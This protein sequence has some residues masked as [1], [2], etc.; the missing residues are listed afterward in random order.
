MI[1]SGRR[2]LVRRGGEDN[3]GS[4]LH[5]LLGTGCEAG[6][7]LSLGKAGQTGCAGPLAITQSRQLGWDIGC[8][9][10][11]KS[12]PRDRAGES[13]VSRAPQSQADRWGS[14]KQGM[15]YQSKPGQ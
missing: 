13:G 1:R 14:P 15:C 5:E 9:D 6:S 12:P 7:S 4:C 10:T 2:L 8:S 3:A 11:G